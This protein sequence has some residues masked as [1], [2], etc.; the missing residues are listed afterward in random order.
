MSDGNLGIDKLESN[1]RQEVIYVKHR[2]KNH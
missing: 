2:E 1:Q